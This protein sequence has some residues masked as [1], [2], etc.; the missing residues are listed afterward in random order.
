[1][2]Y[3]RKVNNKLYKMSN[4]IV[5]IERKINRLLDKYENKNEDSNNVT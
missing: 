4:N 2:N 5:H 3:E 1:M